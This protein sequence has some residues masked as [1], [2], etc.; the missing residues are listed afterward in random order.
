[1]SNIPEIGVGSP[2]EWTTYQ[3]TIKS[4]QDKF[5]RCVKARD[6]MDAENLVCLALKCPQSAILEVKVYYPRLT[7]YEVK[8]LHE[9]AGGKFFDRSHMKAHGQRL[10][11][12]SVVKDGKGGYLVT[13][14]IKKWGVNTGHFTKQTFNPN[15]GELNGT[16]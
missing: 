14:P 13:A 6:A 3:A 7:I 12:F 1:M 9:R 15:T 16:R 5:K 11:D 10:K 4:D 8:T 2:R